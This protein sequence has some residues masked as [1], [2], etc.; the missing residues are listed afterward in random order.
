VEEQESDE[1]I[2]SGELADY[3]FSD[4]YSLVD[5]FSQ[6]NNLAIFET[7][8]FDRQNYGKISQTSVNL[9]NLS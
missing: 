7:N 3:F 2:K 8:L 5:I 1:E 6:K 4:D 9:Y